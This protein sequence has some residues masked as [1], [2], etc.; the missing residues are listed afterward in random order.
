MDLSY[1][2]QTMTKKTSRRRFLQL[3]VGGVIGLTIGNKHLIPV[4]NAEDIPHLSE[5]DPQASALKYVNKSTIE[6][7]NCQN[8]ILLRTTSETEWQ[9]CAIF[10][11]KLVNVDGWCSAYAPKPS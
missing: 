7:Q 6:G 9:P 4:V 3:T 10:P 1:K 5:D 11:N 8:C 2:D